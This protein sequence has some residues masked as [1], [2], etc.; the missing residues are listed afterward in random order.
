MKKEEI[1]NWKLKEIIDQVE[2]FH[3][4]SDTFWKEIL[5]R[6]RIPIAINESINRSNTMIDWK[7]FQ[8]HYSFFFDSEGKEESI[9]EKLLQSYL[10]KYDKVIIVYPMSEPVVTVEMNVFINDWEDIF[11]STRWEALLFSPDFKLVMEISHDY[12]LHSNFE[13]MSETKPESSPSNDRFVT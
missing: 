13:I 5:N 3:P 11:A 8:P 12:Y 1:K 4:D 2:I 6:L 9:K 7:I 10:S